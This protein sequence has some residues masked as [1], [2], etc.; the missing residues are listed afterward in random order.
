ME[1]FGFRAMHP[2]HECRGLSHKTF[3]KK[4]GFQEDRT[5]RWQA[6]NPALKQRSALLNWHDR[7][8]NRP[9]EASGQRGRRPTFCD[10]T[11]HLYLF[12]LPLRHAKA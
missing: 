10:E 4:S 8:M 5:L 6:C 7:A 11:I 12:S 2:R 3:V 9:G 1:A